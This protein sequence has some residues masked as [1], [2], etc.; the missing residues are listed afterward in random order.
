MDTI[1]SDIV[2]LFQLQY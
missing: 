2:S 1:L